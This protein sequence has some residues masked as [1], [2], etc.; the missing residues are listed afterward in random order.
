MFCLL[1]ET[2]IS[3]LETKREPTSSTPVI[4]KS[5]VTILCPSWYPVPLKI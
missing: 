3:F 1:I 4:K 2:K 5:D